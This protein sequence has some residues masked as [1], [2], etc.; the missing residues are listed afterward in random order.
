MD[1]DDVARISL[2]SH[3]QS[4]TSQVMCKEFPG[5][6]HLLQ[7]ISLGK[8]KQTQ[9]IRFMSWQDCSVASAKSL[10]PGAA[11]V[12]SKSLSRCPMLDRVQVEYDGCPAG[13][14]KQMALTD[15]PQIAYL[16]LFGYYHV[17]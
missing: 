13:T 14:R 7:Q 10:L 9:T 6:R 8:A 1:F 4:R 16:I 12:S 5:I 11:G 3:P 15:F 17:T 2:A